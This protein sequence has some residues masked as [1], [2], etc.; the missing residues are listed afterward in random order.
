MCKLVLLLLLTL[1]VFEKCLMCNGM[2]IHPPGFGGGVEG[3]PAP[4]RS[5]GPPEIISS[6]HKAVDE[7]EP[8]ELLKSETAGDDCTLVG[9]VADDPRGAV[10]I[11]VSH[12][13]FKSDLLV[14]GI[15]YQGKG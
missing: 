3:D 6:R 5:P 10:N 8:T 11:S 9:D 12:E 14:P 7:L 2:V 1:L 4:G 13:L 15:V